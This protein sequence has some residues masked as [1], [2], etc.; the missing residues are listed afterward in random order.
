MRTVRQRLIQYLIS[1]CKGY[2]QCLIYLP[3]R[4]GEL[5]K[6]LGTIGET[7]SR[8]LKQLQEEGLISVRGNFIQV[9]DCSR[10]KKEMGNLSF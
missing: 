3:I 2:G 9:H 5:A 1:N 6:L 10:L 4:K 7:L 8:N